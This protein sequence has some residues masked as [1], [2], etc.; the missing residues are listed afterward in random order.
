MRL[1]EQVTFARLALISVAGYR[2]W[3][4]PLLALAW[5]GF[6]FVTV[7]LNPA[8]A[9][10]GAAVQERIFN[11]P[12]TALAIYFGMRIIAGEIDDR[13]LEIAYTVPGGC[14][15]LWF[16]KLGA[17]VALLLAA[18]CLVAIPVALFVTTFPP[19]VLYGAMQGA[20]FYLVLTTGMCALFRGEAAG[21]IATGVI[22]AFSFVLTDGGA[23][24]VRFSPFFNPGLIEGAGAEARGAFTSSEELLA[25]TIQ[26][27]IGMLLAMAGILA[28]AF[29]RAN[30][31]EKM[32]EGL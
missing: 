28:L 27:R 19:G 16:A 14:E 7:Q 29:V 25:W 9:V 23:N 2:Y 20:C 6:Y 15:R 3:L 1:R 17:A 13:S 5:L 12:L 11:V 30:R 10:V 8:N 31:R 24:Q 26:N 32:L 22:L 21:A 18:E 4:F